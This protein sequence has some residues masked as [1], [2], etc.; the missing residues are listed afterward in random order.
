MKNL[1][2]Y[3][4]LSTYLIFF[5]TTI[6]CTPSLLISKE[7]QEIKSYS[8]S[9]TIRISQLI[10]EADEL[11]K[12]SKYNNAILKLDTAKNLVLHAS[13]IDSIALSTILH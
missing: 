4:I 11:S 13:D 8:D 7:S 1:A 5:C 10:S 12:I 9:D 3:T 2:F 6:K